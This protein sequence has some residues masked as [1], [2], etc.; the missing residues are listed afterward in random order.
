[1]ACGGKI[2]I[3]RWWTLGELP[4]QADVWEAAPQ[5]PPP[6]DSQAAPKAGASSPV[7]VVGYYPDWKS[8][9]PQ[10]LQ[11]DV[12]THIAYAFAIPT[13]DSR[14]LPLENPETAVRLIEDAHKKPGQGLISCG[15]MEL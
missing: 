12:L 6:A 7:K 4:G 3:A 13:P 10:K 8:Y 11:M 1:M 14:L 5:T 2:Y 9:Q 15:W